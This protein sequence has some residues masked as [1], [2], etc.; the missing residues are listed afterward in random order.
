MMSYFSLRFNPSANYRMWIGI[1]FFTLLSCSGYK[2]PVSLATAETEKLDYVKVTLSNGDEFIYEYIEYQNDGYYGINTVDGEQIK[3]ALQKSDIMEI[4]QKNK[5]SSGF[6]NFMGV[7]IG[8][9][10]IVLLVVML[11]A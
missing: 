2:T 5:K 7:L 9:G 3:T 4:R 1:L 10:S 8:A 11:G 6:L